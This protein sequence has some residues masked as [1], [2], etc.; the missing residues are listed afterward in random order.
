[1]ST[2]PSVRMTCCC[3][4]V[5]MQVGH[6]RGV[7]QRGFSGL[8]TIGGSTSIGSVTGLMS[9]GSVIDSTSIGSVIRSP[10]DSNSHLKSWWLRCARRRCH[11]F[12]VCEFGAVRSILISEICAD[13]SVDSVYRPSSR[14]APR[15]FCPFASAIA[16]IPDRNV[17]V[18]PYVTSWPTDR[19]DIRNSGT[20][21]TSISTPPRRTLPFFFACIWW[22][23]PNLM[24]IFVSLTEFFRKSWRLLP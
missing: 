20:K 10:E 6:N 23:S 14:L 3:C 1:M 22:S 5:W 12:T 19:R 11:M 4:F 21:N 7:S 8:S 13:P 18:Y 2:M 9:M 16:H 24:I 15:T 17:F